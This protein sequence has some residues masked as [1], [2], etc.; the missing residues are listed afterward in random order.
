MHGADIAAGTIASYAVFRP[1]TSTN[2]A[3]RYGASLAPRLEFWRFG[4]KVVE[5]PRPTALT[6]RVTAREDL[7]IV[8]TERYG[9]SWRT[10]AGMFDPHPDEVLADVDMVFSWVDGSSTEFQRQRA[11]QMDGYD[12]GDGDEIGRAHV[13][14]PVT[15]APLV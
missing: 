4:K 5:A 8:E 1:R 12:V 11:A 6:R 15:N 13:L 10:I 7:S 9:R 14:T 2:G 3:Y